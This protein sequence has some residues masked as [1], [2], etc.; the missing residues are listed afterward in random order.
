MKFIIKHEIEGR[1]RVHFAQNRMTYVEADTLLYYLENL[2]FVKKAKVYEQTADAAIVY[3][4][5][6]DNVDNGFARV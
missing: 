1:I 5:E 4:G 3:V 6:R 2:E